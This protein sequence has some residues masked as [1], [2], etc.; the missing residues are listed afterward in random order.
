MIFFQFGFPYNFFLCLFTAL[1]PKIPPL[2]YINLYHLWCEIDHSINC[3]GTS[4]PH[5]HTSYSMLFICSWNFYGYIT[6]KLSH[7]PVFFCMVASQIY[8]LYTSSLGSYSIE[9]YWLHIKNLCF[10]CFFYQWKT[11]Q[12][13][14]HT[15]I[16]IVLVACPMDWSSLNLAVAA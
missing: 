12:S 5:K 3:I 10:L 4:P 9:L 1:K 13:P 6:T 14:D 11:Y 16:Y 15:K 7:T 8:F 2:I